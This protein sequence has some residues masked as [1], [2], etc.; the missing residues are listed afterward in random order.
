MKKPPTTRLLTAPPGA[1][2][3]TPNESAFAEVVGLI[4]A[5]RG[6]ALQAADLELVRE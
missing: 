1:T 4:Q 3:Q 6:R 5:A 2:E